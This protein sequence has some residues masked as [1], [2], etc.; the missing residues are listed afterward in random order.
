MRIAL[1]F[2]ERDRSR[3]LQR[4]DIMHVAKY[5]QEVGHEVFP[6]FGTKQFIPADIA[7]LHVDLSLVPQGF[8][9]FANR[10]AICLNKRAL[11]IRK[12]RVSKNLLHKNDHYTGQVIIKSNEN[13]GGIPERINSNRWERAQLG[14]E[15]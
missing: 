12:S 5:W 11:D 15:Q 1:L 2:H 13:T 7:I 8:V 14:L 3:N 10:Y 9:D 6:V 4:Y